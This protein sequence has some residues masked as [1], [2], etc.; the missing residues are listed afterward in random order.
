MGRLRWLASPAHVLSVKANV[1][2]SLKEASSSKITI[3]DENPEEIQCLLHF[4][5][6]GIYDLALE[7]TL[8]GRHPPPDPFLKL[9]RHVRMYALGDRF[10]VDELQSAARTAFVDVLEI[11][12]FK[13]GSTVIMTS[14]L[15][16]HVYES[17]PVCDRALRNVI[18]K[19]VAEHMAT[20]ATRQ[21]L[22]EQEAFVD[23]VETTTGFAAD[24]VK[25]LGSRE[26]PL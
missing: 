19:F 3:E 6:N 10:S 8:S 26:G 7:K 11:Y 22:F 2:S 21:L 9:D 5:Y 25:V 4:L 12:K 16:P 15:I 1:K 23:I 14:A 18:C 13:R 24:L 20:A 17:T